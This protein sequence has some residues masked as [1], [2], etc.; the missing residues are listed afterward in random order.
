MYLMV[1]RT[2]PI[3]ITIT[4]S[5][6]A[7]LER[8]WNIKVTQIAC[9]C[10]TLAPNGCLQYYYSQSG[11]VRSFNYGTTINGNNLNFGNGSSVAGT[12][13]ISNENYGVCIGMVPGYCSIQWSQSDG[14]TSSFS[15]SNDTAAASVL[16]G[17]PSNGLRGENCTT[18]YVV[19]P[20]PYF[21]NGTA[22]NADRFCGNQFPTVVTSSKPFVL[23]V[24]TNDNELGDAANRG[25]SL[26][27]TQQACSNLGFML[28]NMS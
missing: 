27:Y 17:L 12:R 2:N 23:R 13:Q 14:E 8:S 26:D 1:D 28:Y 24:V 11:N 16:D 7:S 21:V 22:V 20:N 18:D 19:I 15:L 5:V 6:A 9:D 10:P 4:T 3:T 25:F